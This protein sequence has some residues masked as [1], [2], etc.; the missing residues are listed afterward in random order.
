MDWFQ[1]V[2]SFFWALNIILLI[3]GSLATVIWIKRRDQKTTKTPPISILKPL[4]G[5]DP[6][7][8]ES[9]E[10]FLNLDYPQFE[11]IFSVADDQDPAVAV[12]RKLLTKY[13]KAPAQLIIGEEIVGPNPKVNNLMRSLD[14]AQH[15]LVVI[16]DSYIR[17]TTDYLQTLLDVYGPETGAVTGLRRGYNGQGL[18]GKLEEYHMNGFYLRW[19]VL[20]QLIKLEFVVGSTM[21]FARSVCE[22]LGG[23]KMISEYASED[24][25]FGEACRRQRKKIALSHTPVTQYIGQK[26]F[27]DF[28]FRH[29]RWGTIRKYAAPQV[30]FIEWQHGAVPAAIFAFFT[31]SGLNPD[32]GLKAVVAT[33]LTWIICDIW[34]ERAVGNAWLNP[35]IWLIKELIA[36]FNWLH[37]I[38]SRHI[39]WRGNRLKL[40]LGGRVRAISN[41]KTDH[42][43]SLPS[44]S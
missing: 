11:V 15:E 22:R 13:P 6:G 24:Y 33:L 12:V 8:Y 9:L 36:P 5:V 20:G 35:G 2:M 43:Q 23:F 1:A 37:A 40:L 38:A 25:A 19:Q 7:L 14:A 27:R 31:F 18:G 44:A 3:G 34:V 39:V 16:S 21:M 32:F 42:D 41:T 10:T 30:F 29:Q 26:S 17:A 28:W 4:K